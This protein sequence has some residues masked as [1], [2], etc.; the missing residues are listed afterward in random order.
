MSKCT[1]G[2]E[3]TAH[4]G[5]IHS[6]KAGDMYSPRHIAL[7]P[8]GREVFERQT[9]EREMERVAIRNANMAIDRREMRDS[10]M[11][12]IAAFLGKI[13]K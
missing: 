5:K 7:A 4:M 2:F 11:D 1:T 6:L 3:R 12:R 8:E 13:S 9:G 10:V